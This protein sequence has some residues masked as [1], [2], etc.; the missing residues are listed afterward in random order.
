MIIIIN[1]LFERK[2]WSKYK[3]NSCRNK[4]LSGK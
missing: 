4:K 2:W 3:P 1:K